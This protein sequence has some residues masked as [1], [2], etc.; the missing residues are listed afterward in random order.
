MRFAGSLLFLTMA[1]V[2]VLAGPTALAESVPVGSSTLITVLDYSDTFTAY[3]FGGLEDRTGLNHYPLG[4][5]DYPADGTPGEGLTVEDCHG[6]AARS[7]SDQKFSISKDANPINGATVYPGGSGGGSATGMTQTGGL[8]GDFGFEYGLRRRFVVQYD[9]VQTADRVDISIGSVRDNI[10]VGN[11]LSVFFRPTGGAPNEIGVFSL[12]AGGEHGTGFASGVSAGS[13]HNYAVKFDLDART[14]ELCVDEVSC[15]VVDL[16]T[17]AGGAFASLNLTS[18]AVNVGYYGGDRFWSD[19]VQV[20]AWVPEP[21]LLALGL[22]GI[23]GL[24]LVRRGRP[25]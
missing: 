18:A 13:W 7:W 4:G 14:I 25:A 3:D 2:T 19:N 12:G 20:G 9:A 8:W 11:G 1:A 22:G 5:V 21:G 15:G 10:F 24:L 23:G 6:N 16:N 17:F